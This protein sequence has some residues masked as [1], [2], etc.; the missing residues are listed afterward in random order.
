MHPV[1]PIGNNNSFD[2]EQ[3]VKTA[4]FRIMNKRKKLFLNYFLCKQEIFKI[5][6]E[7]NKKERE[8]A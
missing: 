2:S 5:L 4:I 8:K 1:N 6:K 7:T 3:K